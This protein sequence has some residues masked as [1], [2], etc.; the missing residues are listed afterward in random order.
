VS[1]TLWR[2]GA[3][4]PSYAADDMTGKG[5]EITGGRWNAKSAPVVYA[6]STR[7]LAC[8]ET[9][10]HYNAG[11]LPMNRYLVEITVPDDLWAAAEIETTTT[12]AVG[13]DAEPPGYVSIDRGTDWLAS[14]SS[15]LLVVPSVV[16]PEETNVLINP[17]APG[18]SRITAQKV[19]RWLYD[20]RLK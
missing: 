20:P 10:V 1:R 15:V 8:L 7:A 11:G 13:W 12:L 2:I 14:Q 5:A 4:T 3:D 17:L 6:A 16:V 19:R 9:V 18:A